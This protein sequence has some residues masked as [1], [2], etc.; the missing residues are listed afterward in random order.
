MPVTG[1]GAEQLPQKTTGILPDLHDPFL[2]GRELPHRATIKMEVP[3]N[4]PAAIPGFEDLPEEERRQIELKYRFMGTRLR[5]DME[6]FAT[7]PM[8][9][10]TMELP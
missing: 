1:G 8:R 5:Q 9:K 7:V 2:T 6:N 3:N 4:S 10:E